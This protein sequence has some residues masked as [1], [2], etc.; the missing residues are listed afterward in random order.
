MMEID[1]HPPTTQ[2]EPL[3]PDPPVLTHQALTPA[4]APVRQANRLVAHQPAASFAA[5][6]GLMVYL[7]YLSGKE[8]PGQRG[9]EVLRVVVVEAEL[10]TNLDFG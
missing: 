3:H 10:I 8:K 2:Q 6:L 7:G 4:P 9:K 5:G 1:S